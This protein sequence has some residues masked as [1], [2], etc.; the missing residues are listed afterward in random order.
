MHA[1]ESS[2]RDIRFLCMHLTWKYGRANQLL[3]VTFALISEHVD[4]DLEVMDND[5]IFHS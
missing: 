3:T 1:H 4:S 2:S 5:L